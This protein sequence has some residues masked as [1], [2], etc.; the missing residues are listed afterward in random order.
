MN[1]VI[2]EQRA[3]VCLLNNQHKIIHK[4]VYTASL[5]SQYLVANNRVQLSGCKTHQLY[6]LI[7]STSL[8]LQDQIPMFQ[9]HQQTLPLLKVLPIINMTDQM[10]T[11]DRNLR[12]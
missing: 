9:M 11:M 1:L 4:I 7:I 5:L 10:L 8:T 6:M 2:T 3:K 12:I